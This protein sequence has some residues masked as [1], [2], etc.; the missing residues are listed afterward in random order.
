[1]ATS[2]NADASGCTL[3]SNG[4]EDMAGTNFL[5]Q[6]AGYKILISSSTPEIFQGLQATVC[7]MSRLREGLLDE[8]A[9][10]P[11]AA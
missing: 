5:N 3:L 7:Q 11:A 4:G 9:G 8:S 1:M 2:L 10:I 6:G